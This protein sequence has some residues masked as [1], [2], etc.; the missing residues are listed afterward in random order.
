M[1]KKL[2][3][4]EVRKS[5]YVTNLWMW[6]LWWGFLKDIWVSILLRKYRYYVD[7]YF[8]LYFPSLCSSKSFSSSSYR[9]RKLNATPMC[10]FLMFFH[11]LM[12]N[13]VRANFLYL[14]LLNCTNYCRLADVMWK[15]CFHL[16]LHVSNRQQSSSRSEYALHSFIYSPV[17]SPFPL[18]V[19]YV[20]SRRHVCFFSLLKTFTAI[21]E[22]FWGSLHS[23][24]H[25]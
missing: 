20:S 18:V 1:S 4:F 3:K 7:T 5:K 15:M 8:L 11:E 6:S 17:R 12:T 10:F 21:T 2:K 19:M 25:R 14:K 13:P 22:C 23:L 24:L 9:L 16:L